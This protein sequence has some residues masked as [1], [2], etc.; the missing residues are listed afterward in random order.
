MGTKLKLNTIVDQL[1]PPEVLEHEQ[2]QD[3]QTSETSSQ[4]AY[5]P[6]YKTNKISA[7]L[8]TIQPVPTQILTV[9][10]VNNRVLHLE[11]D[12]AATV[13]YIS[14]NEAKARNFKISKNSQISRL[15]DGDTT[16]TACGEITTHL[17]RDDL[18]MIFRALVCTKLHCPVIGGTLFLKENGITHDFTNN[19]I[20]LLHN[21]KIVPATT[22]EATLPVTSHNNVKNNRYNLMSLKTNKIILPG[23]SIDVD[24]HLEDQTVLVEGFN[25][26]HWPPPQVVSISQ[27]KIPI[28]NTSDEPVILTSHKVNS[29][30]VTSTEL[31]DWSTPSYA[32]LSAIT[33]PPQFKPMPDSETIDTIT[34]GDTTENIREM[35]TAANKKF[36]KVF[37]KDLTHGYNGFYGQHKCHLNWASQQRPEARKIHVASYNHSL[38]G[39]MQEL[40]DDLTAQGVLR[41][42]QQHNI[43]VQSVCPSFLTRKR[44]ARDKLLHQLT[45]NDCRLVVNFNP[46]N[47]H[48]KN[49]P[50]PMTT[51]SDIY[52]QLGKWKEIVILDLHNAFF[53]IHMA[54]EDQQWLGIMTPFSGLRVLARSGQGLLGQSEELEELLAKVLGEDIKEGRCVRL[55][56]DIIIGGDDQYDCAKN[57][58]RILEKLFLANL[59]AEPG[60]TII[61]PK[62]VD[63]SGWVWE[64]GGFLKVSPHRRSSLLNTK[65]E[66]F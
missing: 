26:E 14:L 42:P 46:I 2:E 41:I 8:N 13:N 3:D 18:P 11:L 38:K 57:Y 20:S 10:D 56:D 58:V 21:R 61:F 43:R 40:C 36:R 31:V 9:S 25:G 15:G 66:Q 7:G 5:P 63:I 45:K 32:A 50:S 55:Q 33:T 19:T 37:S 44:R 24:T 59:R 39:I 6:I 4:V 47:E 1:L 23:E 29:I 51:V 62:S 48:I 49:I 22:F 35:V 52:S 28:V 54:E 27:G 60:K 34:I 53:Q 30:K 16:I 64:K 12:S 17:Y 65:E